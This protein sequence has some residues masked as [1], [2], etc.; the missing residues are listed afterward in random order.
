[1]NIDNLIVFACALFILAIVP[2]PGVMACVSK[3]IASG[4]KQA[5]FVIMGIIVGDLFFLLMAIFGLAAIAEILGGF[6]VFARYCGG[7]YLIYLGFKFFTGKVNGQSIKSQRT[8]YHKS[9]FWRG[10]IIT[11]GNPKAIVFYLSFLPTFIDL[12]D[13]KESDILV[14]MI[15]VMSVISTVLI[16]YSF[17]AHQ[18]RRIFQ[19]K[20]ATRKMNKCSGVLMIMAGTS[21][22][23]K[24]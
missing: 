15:T 18:V 8:V 12:K 21:L 19:T 23:I 7:L 2:G 11:L 6:F 24:D 4:F 20:R 10:F 5:V 1:M 16:T 17:A 13:L 14:A 3:S 22:V 9:S